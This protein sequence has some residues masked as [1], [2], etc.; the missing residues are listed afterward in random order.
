MFI[1]LVYSPPKKKRGS[2]KQKR[3][4]RSTIVSRATVKR[5]TM[6]SRKAAA[7]A[8]IPDIH[9][10]SV[11]ELREAFDLFDTK[12]AGAW[13]TKSLDHHLLTG[14]Y[15]HDRVSDALCDYQDISPAVCTLVYCSAVS[16]FK[17]RLRS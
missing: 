4:T 15:Q 12:G 17:R 1:L 8:D 2:A 9:A 14:G 7:K 10:E 13:E 5:V 16:N 6:S 3:E 11:Q